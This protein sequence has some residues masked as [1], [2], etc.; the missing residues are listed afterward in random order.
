[1]RISRDLSTYVLSS[2]KNN[3]RKVRAYYRSHATRE[4]EE[5]ARI[6]ENAT[7]VTKHDFVGASPPDPPRALARTNA[8]G[9][10]MQLND[11]PLMVA[12][13]I[14]AVGKLRTRVRQ[15]KERQERQNCLM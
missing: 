10:R 6:I 4:G 13:K 7:R 12:R 5:A 2:E 11:A 1:M 8:K 3:K 14:L 15:Q 9:L